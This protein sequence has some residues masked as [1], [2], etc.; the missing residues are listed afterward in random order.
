MNGPHKQH[1]GLEISHNS[2]YNSIN[3]WKRNRTQRYS[4]PKLFP[5]KNVKNRANTLFMINIYFNKFEILKVH[6]HT[7]LSWRCAEMGVYRVVV[8]MRECQTM[9]R[10]HRHCGN[11][12]QFLTDRAQR[13]AQ[14]HFKNHLS[15]KHA[16]SSLPVVLHLLN[17]NMAT[18]NEFLK[19]HTQWWSQSH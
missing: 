17:F 18:D 6:K 19:H 16:Q 4:L 5:C 2:G 10:I 7:N 1:T 13:E 14:R 8:G 15:F 9:G 12:T 11:H 3:I